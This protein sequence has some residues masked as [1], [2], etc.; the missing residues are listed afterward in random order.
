MTGAVAAAEFGL[1]DGTWPPL[2]IE[3]ELT[4]PLPWMHFRPAS[5]TSHLDESSMMGT[6]EMSGSEA[7]R[8]RNGPSRRRSQHRLVHVDVDHLGAVL[9][10]LAGHRQ[11]VVKRP[12]EDHAG[13]GARAGDV[14]AFADV[15]EKR[16]GA[17]VEGFRPDSAGAV[18]GSEAAR[19]D[20]QPGRRWRGCGRGGA[21]A[22]ADDIEP[23]PVRAQRLDPSANMSGSSS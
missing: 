7:I 20:R 19:Y 16:A 5:M 2:F 11:R 4:I 9:D 17:D 14:G 15:D 23:M 18:P 21:A 10:L 22:A 3:I 12:F 13:E 8:L 6:R 1:F